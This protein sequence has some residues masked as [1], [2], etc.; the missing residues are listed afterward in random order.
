M[1]QSSRSGKR[2][3]KRGSVPYRVGLATDF[4]E[5]ANVL[6][7]AVPDPLHISQR[8]YDR[9]AEVDGEIAAVVVA[10]GM[11]ALLSV[12]FMRFLVTDQRRDCNF[13]EVVEIQVGGI[14]RRARFEILFGVLFGRVGGCESGVQGVAEEDES[15]ESVGWK[16]AAHVED[17]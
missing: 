16:V 7:H 11:P 3:G 6:G 14:G 2:S 8:L 12:I 10:S 9:C 5:G 17:G 13:V 4:V 1:W 15:E